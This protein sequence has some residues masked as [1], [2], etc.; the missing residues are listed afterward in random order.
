M[1]KLTK[2]KSLFNKLNISNKNADNSNSA[3]IDH[4][5]CSYCN[6]PFTKKLWCK[7]C[8]PFR[9]IEGWSSGNNEIDKFIKDTIYDARNRNR[10]FLEWVPFYKFEN[11]KQI[12]E[13]GFSK[14]YSATWIDGKAKYTR[15][16]DL[17]WK[18]RKPRPIKVALKRLNGSE[19]MSSEYS[20][21]IKILWDLCQINDG[22][23]SFYGMTKDP[24]TEELIIIS[25]YADKGNLRSILSHNFHNTLWK[26]KLL[27]LQW[28][29]PTAEE[30]YDIIQFWNAST[31]SKARQ[32]KKKFGYKGKEIKAI[33][34]E[35]DK[36]I[37]N[38][39]TLY[40]KNPDAIYTSR[41]FTFSNLTKPVNS[42]I[43][44]D[45]LNDGESNKDCQDSQ[46]V[47]LEVSSSF[48]NQ[49][50]SLAMKTIVD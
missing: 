43:I 26:D 12:G 5:N 48:Y 35:A 22:C 7:K 29:I 44:T 49:K 42:S 8:D 10:K 9:I 6:K 2:L 15:K 45:Y 25:E 20:N 34:K 28:I 13:G 14:V 47:D 31:H 46:L 18:K 27:Y 30:L 50:M 36:E 41:L 3:N 32:K 21:E 39:S 24:E 37:P 23:L 40:E 1:F 19:N 38:I 11:I 33:F 17:S 4:K 16:Y